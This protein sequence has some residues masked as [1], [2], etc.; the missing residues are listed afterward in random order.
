MNFIGFFNVERGGMYR[1][2][3]KK[4]IVFIGFDHIE[5]VKKYI[6]Y[7]FLNTIRK[8]C[9]YEQQNLALTLDHV[10][11][12]RPD[13]E[14]YSPTVIT[15]FMLDGPEKIARYTMN[16]IATVF[17]FDKNRH[18]ITWE[19]FEYEDIDKVPYHRCVFG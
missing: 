10:E 11:E 16:R 14:H 18:F 19:K 4:T 2:D 7:T 6:T 8:E 3:L 1:Q 12:Y 15:T 9:P 5:Q 13:L 17:R